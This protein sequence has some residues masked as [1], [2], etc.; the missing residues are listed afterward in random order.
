MK[1]I[2]V[3]LSLI[4]CAYTCV[5]QGVE[6]R[7]YVG[8]TYY[9]GDLSPLP[10]ALSFSKGHLAVGTSV[11][12]V[13]NPYISFHT[14]VLVGKVSG[15]D[16]DA[17]SIGRRRRNLSFES[18]LYEWG[19]STELSLNG[20][21]KGINKFGVNIYFTGGVNVFHFNPKAKLDGTWHALQ[22]LGTEG[23][24][25]L[26]GKLSYS[27]TQLSIAHGVGVR[28][29]LSPVMVMG[30]EVAPRRTFTD[31]LDDVST[32][33]VNYSE[34]LEGNGELAATLANRTGEY[35]GS[36][37]VHVNTGTG[38]GDPNDKDW[39]LFT[40]M[41]VGYRFGV[42]SLPKVPVAPV[43]AAGPSTGN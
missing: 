17:S 26:P 40:G 37:P 12:L 39:Y 19:V 1:K 20:L 28:F 43:E 29:N 18:D 41:Y 13:V 15:N 27:L 2:F 9:Q 38:R 6:L 23:Q 35:L 11:G 25:L 21:I 30:F 24:G 10:T 42:P 5:A 22:P 4:V 36:S 34:L 7:S 33:Y 16:A 3:I 14:K 32:E 8:T 31:Y